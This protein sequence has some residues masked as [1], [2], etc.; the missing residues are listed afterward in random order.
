MKPHI[1]VPRDALPS[2][3]NVYDRRVSDALQLDV[4]SVAGSWPQP[5]A[6]AREALARSLQALPDGDVVLVDGLVAC[7]VPDVVEPAAKRLNL[8]VL[9]HAPLG[10]DAGLEPSVAADLD[11]RERET[12]AVARAVVATS[13]TAARQLA[14][15]HGLARVDVAPP[16]VDP[17]P[18]TPGSSSGSRLLCVGAVSRRKGQDVLVEALAQVS[19]L[20]WSLRCAG[21]L[22]DGPF[23]DRMRE[24]IELRGLGDRI[25]LMGPL[26]GAQL[27]ATYAAADLLVLP[28]RAETYGMVLTEAL[29]RG[30]PVLASDIGGVHEAVGVSPD[31]S[32]PGVLVPPGDATTLARELRRWLTEPA[33]RARLRSS[34][35][36]R[37]ST[38]QPWAATAE[39][40]SAVLARLAVQPC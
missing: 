5:D 2:G 18:L 20:P 9:V 23:A 22:R 35:R 21:P 36:A 10:D 40:L 25:Q 12:L 15:R 38:L 13:R 37:R 6:A 4:I 33:H 19:E 32:S 16:G 8:G 31:G 7:G 3:G 34:A 1:V 24:R 29:A 30:I 26:H 14:E 39:Q 17:A 11:R 28:S 27:H